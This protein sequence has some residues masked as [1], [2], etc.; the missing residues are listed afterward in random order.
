[1]EIGSGS[2][3]LEAPSGNRYATSW[4]MCL[5]MISFY[6]AMLHRARLCIQSAALRWSS[7]NSYTLPLQQIVGVF[8]CVL[9]NV[10]NDLCVCSIPVSP[11]RLSHGALRSTASGAD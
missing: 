8:I 3:T 2:R 7:I 9:S 4:G 11:R 1:M 10:V 6:H 5:M